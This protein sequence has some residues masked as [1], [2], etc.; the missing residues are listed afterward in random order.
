MDSKVRHWKDLGLILLWRYQGPLQVLPVQSN[1]VAK[2]AKNTEFRHFGWKCFHADHYSSATEMT[3]D[4]AMDFRHVETLL[5]VLPT[6]PLH[7]LNV[8]TLKSTCEI[9]TFFTTLDFGTESP[10]C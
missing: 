6:E 8:L 10:S 5:S 4:L 9:W 3:L 7:D 1:L 2:L